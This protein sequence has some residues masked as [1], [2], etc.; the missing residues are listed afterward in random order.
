[1]SAQPRFGPRFGISQPPGGH[2]WNTTR[3]NIAN[4]GTIRPAP[5]PG[6]QSPDRINTLNGTGQCPDVSVKERNGTC[7][8]RP[9]LDL[10]GAR[11]L[12]AT[13]TRIYK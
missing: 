13:S 8:Y 2:R 12:T 5:P 7:V 11:L 6:K 10:C 4:D 1:M 9:A 3:T